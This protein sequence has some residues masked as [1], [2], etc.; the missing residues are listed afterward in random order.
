MSILPS[1]ARN[2]WAECCSLSRWQSLTYEQAGAMTHGL[3][4]DRASLRDAAA[5]LCTSLGMSGHQ[6]VP[7]H[8]TNRQAFRAATSRRPV[9]HRLQMFA[10][11]A[12]ASTGCTHCHPRSSP[13][14]AAETCVKGRAR[15]YVDRHECDG[16]QCA[17]LAVVRHLLFRCNQSQSLASHKVSTASSRC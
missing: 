8:D 5:P 12:A 16:S 7:S 15:Q 13:A 1:F 3:F 4:C 9:R 11:Q 14:L 10:C 17:D 6:Q 2:E